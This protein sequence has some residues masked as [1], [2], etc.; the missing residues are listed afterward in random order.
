MARELNVRRLVLSKR[1]N[2]K[3][4]ASFEYTVRDGDLQKGGSSN[5]DDIDQTKSIEDL[6]SEF[7]ASKGAEEN[8]PS[9]KK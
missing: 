7:E 4:L 2:G 6:L 9:E 1:G 3:M 5:E 8:V